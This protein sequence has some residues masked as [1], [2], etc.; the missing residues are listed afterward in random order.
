MHRRRVLLM[1][2]TEALLLGLLGTC[3]GALVGSVL[4]LLLNAAHIAMPEGVQWI[5]MSDHLL[6]SLSGVKVLFAVVFL[7]LLTCLSAIFPSIRAA[8]L[9]P[10]TA[11]HHLG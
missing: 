3:A 5:L 8:R 1:F 7:S 10:V 2:L 4:V 11:M 9:K 6:L